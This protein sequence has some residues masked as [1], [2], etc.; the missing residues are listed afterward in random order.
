M[1]IAIFGGRD[2]GPFSETYN[3][4]SRAFYDGDASYGDGDVCH[5]PG[6]QTRMLLQQQHDVVGSA[7]AGV[8]DVHGSLPFDHV[9]G[10]GDYGLEPFWRGGVES[11]HRPVESA[12]D[13]S[14]PLG[15]RW[16]RA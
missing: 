2:L 8:D 9:V 5:D 12:R 14:Q 16:P 6:S 3:H 11:L 1:V 13:R 7:A 10:D 4:S 15:S